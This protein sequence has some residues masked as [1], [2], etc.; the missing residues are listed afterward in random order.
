LQANQ[1]ETEALV[2]SRELASG[3]EHGG[4]DFLYEFAAEFAGAAGNGGGLVFKHGKDMKQLG[5]S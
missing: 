2:F 3:P 4:I 1:R 5:R